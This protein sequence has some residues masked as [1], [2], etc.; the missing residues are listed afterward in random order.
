MSS[1]VILPVAIIVIV[2]I[3][4]A[5][6]VIKQGHIGVVTRFGKYQRLMLPGL[7]FKTPFVESVFKSISTQNQSIE[8]EFEAISLDQAYVNFK[9]LIVYSA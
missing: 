5:T 7:N 2:L 8:L 6:T 1:A 3:L 9:S 4:F